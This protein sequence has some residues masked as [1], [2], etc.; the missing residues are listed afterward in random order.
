MWGWTIGGNRREGRGGRFVCLI[1]GRG[2]G[3]G[4]DRWDGG[5]GEM[6]GEGR[7]FRGKAKV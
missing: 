4:M 6:E 1:D 3:M 2:W 5:K 7:G